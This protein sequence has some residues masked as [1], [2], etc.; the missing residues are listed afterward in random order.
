M[1]WYLLK[2]YPPKSL[3]G[4][5]RASRARHTNVKTFVLQHLISVPRLSKLSE[6][7]TCHKAQ[8]HG[9]LLGRELMAG[10]DT[11][12]PGVVPLSKAVEF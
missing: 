3:P 5:H 4:T 8:K 9:Q 7:D 12:A 11:E 10:V 2:R 6:R 1:S